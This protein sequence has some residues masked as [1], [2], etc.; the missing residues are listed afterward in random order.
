[1]AWGFWRFFGVSVRGFMLGDISFNIV[2]GGVG[3]GRVGV[4]GAVAW[5]WRCDGWL[6]GHGLMLRDISFNNIRV[7][8]S[9][10]YVA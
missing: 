9:W 10:S 7:G 2:W 8:R 1:M 6:C 3:G 5:W 4:L